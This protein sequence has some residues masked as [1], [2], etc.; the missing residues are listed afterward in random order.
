[1]RNLLILIVSFCLFSCSNSEL[2]TLKAENE[3][4]RLAVQEQTSRAEEY[5]L[6]AE[7]A[8]ANAREAEARAIMAMAQAD[9]ALKDCKGK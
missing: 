5:I 4:L 8:A 2:E 3:A 9:Q 6:M 1:M 7:D